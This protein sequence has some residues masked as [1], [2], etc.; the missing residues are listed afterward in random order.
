MPTIP[1]STTIARIGGSRRLQPVL[2]D[3]QEDEDR[4]GAA[5]DRAGQAAELG[6]GAR[7]QPGHEGEDQDPDDDDVD[8]V[9]RVSIAAT[10]RLRSQSAPT[11]GVDCAPDVAAW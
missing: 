1:T 9:H 5:A 3:R 11:R 10:A 4:Q 2:G 6:K 7:G 8:Q